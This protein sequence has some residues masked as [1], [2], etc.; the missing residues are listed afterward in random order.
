MTFA[1]RAAAGQVAAVVFGTARPPIFAPML[2]GVPLILGHGPGPEIRQPLGYAMVGGL[3]VSQA[4]TLFTAGD[5]SLSGPVVGVGLKL[6]RAAPR[7]KLPA[8]PEGRSV[9]TLR[10]WRRR[11]NRQTDIRA[12]PSREYF[13][14]I[15]P[16]I[17]RPND[18]HRDRQDGNVQ[19]SEK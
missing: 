1:A 13:G 10:G 15:P 19:L 11:N 12:G 4:L 16:L 6:A 2:G 8:L 9:T 7:Q 17:V 5:L 3:I 18:N 14:R